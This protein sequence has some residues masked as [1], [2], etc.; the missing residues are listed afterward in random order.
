MVRHLYVPEI[1]IVIRQHF[2]FTSYQKS[3]KIEEH[4][5]VDQELIPHAPSWSVTKHGV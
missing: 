4:F 2:C 3:V 1:C 5:S